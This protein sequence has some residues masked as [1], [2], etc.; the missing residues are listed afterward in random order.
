MRSPMSDPSI[1]CSGRFSCWILPTQSR[2][3][4]A[5]ERPWWNRR[6]EA[7]HK[8]LKENPWW[9]CQFKAL[10]EGGLTGH[11]ITCSPQLSVLFVSPDTWSKHPSC[12]DLPCTYSS[13]ARFNLT[14]FVCLQYTW[15]IIGPNSLSSNELH[16]FHFAA[17]KKHVTCRV[18]VNHYNQTIQWWSYIITEKLR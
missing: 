5:L 15:G 12:K 14:W 9:H 4:W 17:L 8:T 6:K 18:G 13:Y 16:Q 3:V 2:G 7:T 10:W 11:W 1:H